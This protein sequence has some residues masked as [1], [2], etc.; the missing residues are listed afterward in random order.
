M[1]FIVLLSIFSSNS[2]SP[3]KNGPPETTKTNVQT[4]NVAPNVN[5]ENTSDLNK[6]VSSDKENVRDTVNAF[7][8]AYFK[9]DEAAMKDYSIFQGRMYN[10]IDVYKLFREQVSVLSTGISV[11]KRQTGIDV[12]V[13]WQVTNIQKV[14]TNQYQVTIDIEISP[15]RLRFSPVLVEKV[16]GLWY[17]DSESF[18]TASHLALNGGL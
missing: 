2:D 1:A 17:V 10:N 6:K 5:K 3:K 15:D 9:N 8:H 16:D 7:M 13:K 18:A 12:S 4:Q 11:Y 14:K